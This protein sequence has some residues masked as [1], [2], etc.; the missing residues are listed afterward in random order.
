MK[1]CQKLK[2][3]LKRRKEGKEEKNC[4]IEAFLNF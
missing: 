3:I 1:M 4:D 2:K